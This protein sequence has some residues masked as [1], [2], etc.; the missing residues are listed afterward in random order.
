MV[1]E[2]SECDYEADADLEMQEHVVEAHRPITCE[3]VMRLANEAADRVITEMGWLGTREGD[4]INLTL[5]VLG[6]M[7][8]G[9]D[10]TVNE[11][12]DANF[13]GGADAVRS[14]WPGWERD[15]FEGPPLS[16]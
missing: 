13:D 11:V 15:V 6:R 3:E 1:L 8:D 12:M 9:H 4:A 16:R 7:L 5:N 2:C 10:G 14:W